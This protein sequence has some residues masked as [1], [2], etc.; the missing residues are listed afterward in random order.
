M[1]KYYQ[2][3]SVHDLKPGKGRKIRINKK[4]I[5]L[6]K[7]KNNIFAIQNRCPHQNADLADGYIKEGRVY[8]M[9]HQWAFDLNS[10]AYSF[11]PNVSIQTFEVKIEDDMIYVGIETN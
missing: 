1:I 4:S 10:G 9:L 6:F 5:A 11:N 2:A 7:Y 3:G 8:C